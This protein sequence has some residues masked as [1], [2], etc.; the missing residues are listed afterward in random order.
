M[1]VCVGCSPLLHVKV[2]LPRSETYEATAIVSD[3]MSLPQQ[4]V[5]CQDHLLG[6]RAGWYREITVQPWLQHS[7]TSTYT[8]TYG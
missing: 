3:L 5:F 1:E 6:M 7:T 8:P 4:A 2:R